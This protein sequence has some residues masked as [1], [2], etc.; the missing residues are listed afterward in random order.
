MAF[1]SATTWLAPV[2]LKITRQI[3]PCIKRFFKTDAMV[4]VTGSRLC[5]T[6]LFNFWTALRIVM[7]MHSHCTVVPLPGYLENLRKINSSLFSFDDQ[8]FKFYFVRILC[9]PVVCNDVSLSFTRQT[10]HYLVLL[11]FPSIC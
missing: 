10:I 11:S 8:E 9:T 3:P 1:M 6:I 7:R 4:T 2:N 5:V